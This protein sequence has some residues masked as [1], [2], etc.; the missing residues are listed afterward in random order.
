M[1]NKTK[2]IIIGLFAGFSLILLGVSGVPY[3]KLWLPDDQITNNP[4]FRGII[5]LSSVTFGIGFVFH[6]YHKY[7]DKQS[8]D[9]RTKK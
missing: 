6:T 2:N 8:E 4:I 9:L 3:Y 1:E 5:S 7:I